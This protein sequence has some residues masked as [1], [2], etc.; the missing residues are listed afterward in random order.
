MR[1]TFVPPSCRVPEIEKGIAC[2]P[3]GAKAWISPARSPLE[4]RPTLRQQRD[5]RGTGNARAGPVR[6]RAAPEAC[7]TSSRTAPCAGRSRTGGRS[8]DSGRISRLRQGERK[9]SWRRAPQGAG[10]GGKEMM[11][12]GVRANRMQNPTQ[13]PA[14]NPVQNRT[15]APTV[16]RAADQVVTGV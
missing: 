2:N 6:S 5:I 10:L 3:S 16:N 15:S 7:G 4:R 14:Q 13:N 8:A 1:V 9:R 11:P 12:Q